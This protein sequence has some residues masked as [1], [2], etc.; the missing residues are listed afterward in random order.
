MGGPLNLGGR[1][2]PQIYHTDSALAN[3]LLSQQTQSEGP[4]FGLQYTPQPEIDYPL[5]PAGPANGY[6]SNTARDNAS[7]THPSTKYGSPRDDSRQFLSP[8]NHLSTLDAPM[9]ASFDS[10]GI[11]YIARH[12]PVAASMPSKFGLESPPSSLPKKTGNPSSALRNL[13]NSAF[14]QEARNN[15]SNLG[16]SP[17]GSGDE[18][19]SRRPLRSQ[20]VSK[21]T[22]ISA[23]VPRGRATDEWDDGI[24]FGGEE[25]FLPTSLHDLLTPQEKMRRL[26]R[27][28]HDERALRESLSGA[29]TPAEISSNVGSPSHASPSRFSAFFTKQRRDEPNNQNASAL[30]FGHIGSP[31]RHSSMPLGRSSSLR[32]TSNPTRSG[33][34]SPYLASPPR[35]SSMSMISQQLARTRILSKSEIGFSDATSPSTLHPSSARTQVQPS[36]GS[37]R[38]DRAT[39]STNMNN[40]RIDEEQGEGVFSMEVE[41]EE[42]Q[43][44]RH[45]GST[46][47]DDQATEPKPDR[48]QSLN[49]GAIGTGRTQRAHEAEKVAKEYW[50]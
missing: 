6:E 14:G 30:A 23:S 40:H 4:S 20:L 33:D 39:S 22:M 15:G 19:Y 3:S 24:M 35:Q 31:L 47:N 32:A 7:V 25:D 13:H 2:D 48:R 29:G 8:G 45:S 37:S 27:T 9:P 36:A 49:L 41:E 26:S 38:L 5:P 11:S 50:T 21:P 18:G 28:E 16:S 43:R 42:N 17:L 12:G 46:W 34:V 1:V 44:N 10:Q